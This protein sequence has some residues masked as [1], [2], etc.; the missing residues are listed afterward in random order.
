MDRTHARLAAAA[1]VDVLRSERHLRF[2][3][4]LPPCPSARARPRP[5]GRPADRGLDNI[6]PIVSWPRRGLPP[7]PPPPPP[8]QPLSLRPP[9]WPS[10][11][12]SHSGRRLHSGSSDVRRFFSAVDAVDH[13]GGQAAVG[14]EHDDATAATAGSSSAASDGA[15]VS[16][17]GPKW[18]GWRRRRRRRRGAPGPATS[19]GHVPQVGNGRFI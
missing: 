16:S 12:V 6:A 4:A 3:R 10:P 9:V 2:S 14:G 13:P 1:A 18:R 11:P 7:P 5:V 8:P 19:L 17:A 15:S